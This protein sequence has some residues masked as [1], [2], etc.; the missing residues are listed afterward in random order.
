[1]PD[2]LRAGYER[3]LAEQAA[4]IDELVA[5]AA[6]QAEQI[7]TLTRLLDDSRRGGKRQ[8][9]PFSKGMPTLDPNRPG[10]KP[11]Q[12]TFK[13]RAVP[14]VADREVTAG[15]P[16]ACPC[17]GDKVVFVKTAEQ[18]QTEL[19][20]PHAI[21]TKFTV[22]IG[23]CV[24]CDR[25]VQG[26][27]E[28]QTSD[29]LGA[30]G[31]Q[32]GPRVKTIAHVL[33]YRHGLSFMRCAELLGLL[34]VKVTAGALV[35]AA[36][37]TA[38]DLDVTYAAILAG[39]NQ[40][41][42]VTMDETGWRI[43]G[44]S[45]WL[46]TATT[47]TMTAYAVC[48]GRSFD[49]A[50]RLVDATFNGTLIRDGWIVYQQYD[51]A[52]HQPCCAHLLRRCAEML[53]QLPVHERGL[54]RQV[55]SLLLEALAARD[56]TADERGV[57]AAELADRLH[58]ITTQAT[59]GE[60]NRKL[61]KHLRREAHAVFTFLTT[62]DVEATNWRAEQAIRPAVVNR[63]VWGGNRTDHGAWVWARLVTFLATARQQGLDI[64]SVLTN[65]ARQPTPGFAIPIP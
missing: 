27:H 49:D 51:K 13:R 45:A 58:I 65:L 10:R 15:L 54:A 64:L 60:S 16:A 20:V 41:A 22:E 4:R 62:P 50:C 7:V 39:I 38:S 32:L 47:A 23:R 59:L 40:S 36:A 33:H 55:K 42:A 9:A 31:S 48:A 19:P 44:L 53:E 21:V 52:S 8:A 56:L 30:A 26:R 2:D 17:C 5:L 43:G 61:A 34:G 11:G 6:A 14:P 12:G 24:G 35:H 63:K 18:W 46:W 28:E 57:A 3:K 29:A 1:M 25:R 37:V